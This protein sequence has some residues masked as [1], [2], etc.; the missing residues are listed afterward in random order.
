MITLVYACAKVIF[1][2]SILR[3]FPYSLGTSLARAR[4]IARKS[5]K[6]V[7][8]CKIGCKR[9]DYSGSREDALV[10]LKYYWITLHGAPAK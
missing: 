4:H 1:F 10:R 8:M 2:L 3:P 5:A 7:I 6:G 9:E